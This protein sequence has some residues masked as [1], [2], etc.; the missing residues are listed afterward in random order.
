MSY[1]VRLNLENPTGNQITT[2]IPKGML[3]EVIDSMSLVENMM[4]DRDYQIQ[5]EPYERKTIE[6]ECNCANPSFRSPSNTPVR[7]TP[8]VVLASLG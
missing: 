4:V 2:D 5:L 6:I 7:V 8:F 3:F 1:R